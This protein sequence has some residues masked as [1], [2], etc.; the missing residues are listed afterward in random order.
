MTGKE[1][2]TGI[3]KR[4]PDAFWWGSITTNEPLVDIGL[5]I[6]RPGT[7]VPIINEVKAAPHTRSVEDYV[8]YPRVVWSNYPPRLYIAELLIEANLIEPDHLLWG[9]RGNETIR[10][11][12]EKKKKYQEDH[13]IK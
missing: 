12:L 10:Q 4:Y 8:S 2:I 9:Y 7:A 13:V 11:H 1:I 3:Y 5:I 6:D